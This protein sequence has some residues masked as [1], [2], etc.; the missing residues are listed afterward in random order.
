MQPLAA[1]Y[2]FLPSGRKIRFLS[3]LSSMTLGSEDPLRMMLHGIFHQITQFLYITFTVPR[4]FYENAFIKIG[5]Y[6]L[7]MIAYAWPVYLT[8]EAKF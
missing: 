7:N 2:S 3:D 5:I 4:N 1:Q 8:T 6:I